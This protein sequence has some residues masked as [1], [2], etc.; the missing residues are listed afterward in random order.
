M[1]RKTKGI[2][3]NIEWKVVIA[4]LFL[5]LVGWLNIYAAVYDGDFSAALPHPL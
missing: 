2:M 1:D 3:S 4:Y 5:L